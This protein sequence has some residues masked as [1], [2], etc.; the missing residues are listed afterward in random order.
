MKQDKARGVVLM[1][2]TVYLEKCLDILDT[3]QF[4]KLSRDP[5]KKIEEKDPTSFSEN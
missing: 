5:T 1:D 2:R 3:N 4:T